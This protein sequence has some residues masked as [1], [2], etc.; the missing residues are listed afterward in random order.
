M[1]LNIPLK[2]SYLILCC[3][4]NSMMVGYDGYSNNQHIS[5]RTIRAIGLFCMSV[6]NPCN[7]S[8]TGPILFIFVLSVHHIILLFNA[9]LFCVFEG[10]R[11]VKSHARADAKHNS[12][13]AWPYS[14]MQS[15]N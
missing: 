5:Q 15:Y 3:K 7:F 9:T 8:Q 2:K 13:T 14:G 1:G 11:R 12:Y 6:I 10:N 4:K